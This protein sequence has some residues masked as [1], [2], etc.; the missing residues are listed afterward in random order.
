MFPAGLGFL[1][2]GT[3]DA[4]SWWSKFCKAQR[5]TLSLEM[6][7][8]LSSTKIIL[9]YDYFADAFRAKFSTNCIIG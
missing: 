7:D 1:D 2:L 9:Y 3:K 8:L 4:E 5:Q 6:F